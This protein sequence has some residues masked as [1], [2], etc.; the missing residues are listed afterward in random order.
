[1][2]AYESTF[3]QFYPLGLVGAPQ[4][5]PAVGDAD[6]EEAERAN[7]RINKL[8][9][10][11]PYLR[12]LG[13]GSIILNPVFASSWHGYDTR[14]LR[15]ID[16]RLGTNED[17]V[18]IVK[19]LHA[20]GVRIL[21][22]A[23]FN[24]VG[25]EFWAFRDVRERKWDSPY[26]D[27]FHISF[28]G[29]TH[30][31]DGFWYEGWEGNQDLV[32]LNLKN[33]A[34]VDY[35]LDS[36]RM[37]R[38]EL[39][40]DGLRL[41]VAYSLDHDFLRRLRE[42]ANELSAEP[43]PAVTQEAVARAEGRARQGAPAQDLVEAQA[44]LSDRTFFLLGE[45]LHGD[46]NLIMN[47]QMLHSCTN[48]ECYKGLYSSFNSMNLF[49]IA[50]SLNRQFG[51]EQWC[52]YRGKHLL[53]FTDNHDVSRLASI[54]T[55]KRHLV[56][57]YGLLLG[58]PGIPCLYYGSEWG[59]TGEKGQGYEADKLIRPELAAP[60]RSALVR[61]KQ[62]IARLAGTTDPAAP[63]GALA[64][65]IAHLDLGSLMSD[66]PD[67]L[68]ALIA[69]MAEVRA[70]SRA[71]AYG[72]YH[73]VNI[74]NKQLLFERV[75][76]E[77]GEH[78]RE[79]VLVAVNAED[80]PHT[81]YDGTLNCWFE[82][83]LAEGAAGAAARQLTG[84]LE[85]P[86]LSVVWLREV[87]AGWTRPGAEDAPAGEKSPAGAE[88]AALTVGAENAAQASSGTGA[89]Q[90]DSVG[91]TAHVNGA[92]DATQVEME[93]AAQ[94]NS[95]GGAH[96]ANAEAG[97]SATAAAAG[98]AGSRAAM[99]DTSR[100]DTD[101]GAGADTATEP[102]AKEDAATETNAQT[103]DAPAQTL[104]LLSS[105]AGDDQTPP[106]IQRW[107]TTAIN[108][109]GLNQA[110]RAGRTLRFRNA[111]VGDFLCAPAPSAI[112]T[113]K[114]AALELNEPEMDYTCTDL[115]DRRKTTGDCMLGAL[116]RRLDAAEPRDVLAVAEPDAVAS[117]LSALPDQNGAAPRSV[118]T[119]TLYLLEYR[120]DTFTLREVVPC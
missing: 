77:D 16:C 27:W 73:N 98:T 101:A 2:W 23:V 28:D 107:C 22:D 35:L 41:D 13:V 12:E 120:N 74:Q 9:A 97:A 57:A 32:K 42:L 69:R 119:G 75:A 70:G 67:A 45:T 46:Y 86:P 1:M 105:A 51:P 31:G 60:E 48:Y 81:F 36:V 17:F 115:L 93:A 50:H 53:T 111:R 40:V 38:R 5:A 89:A 94:V 30:F 103:D 33:P 118:E 37:W 20:H 34:V 29:D 95:A 109:Y 79:R 113:L 44:L 24:H 3:Y 72:D 15:Q 25:R 71:L 54:L 84:S 56:P 90:T 64:N 104:Y 21:L 100:T 110:H 102:S 68:T 78:P 99:P 6:A 14:D 80:A 66:G 26:K 88:G 76:A 52:I 85:V 4:Y 116:A 108:G 117:L 112:D 55:E 18:E 62:Q 83:M 96:A 91:A 65:Q 10:W 61:E 92:D 114:A 7:H 8:A 82:D 106:R 39:G 59:Q 43:A 58:M 87:P 11:A 19:E 47:D 63:L 49:E